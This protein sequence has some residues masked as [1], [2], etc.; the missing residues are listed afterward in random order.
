[1]PLSSTSLGLDQSSS[2]PDS[3][4]GIQGDD[5]LFAPQ[6]SRGYDMPLVSARVGGWDRFKLLARTIASQLLV[7]AIEN[8]LQGDSAFLG[9]EVSWLRR[10]RQLTTGTAA[11]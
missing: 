6:V 1:M 8:V 5:V 11:F 10:R 2:C 7:G 4:L 3:S 9:R